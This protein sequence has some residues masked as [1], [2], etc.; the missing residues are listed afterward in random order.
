LR[1]INNSAR[2]GAVGLT[3]KSM[4]KRFAT[5]W[6][7]VWGLLYWWT[8]VVSSLPFGTTVVGWWGSGM[9][10]AI[11]WFGTAVLQVERPIL[12]EPTGSG[13]GV[14]SWIEA[15]L[16]LVV[17]AGAAVIWLVATRHDNR[18][19]L[20]A[21]LPLVARNRVR[22]GVGSALII[23]GMEKVFALQMPMY[24]ALLTDTIGSKSP[25]GMLWTF[26]GVSSGYQRLTGAAELIAGILL[27]A[28]RTTLL[29][30]LLGALFMGQVFAMNLFFDVP[31]KLLSFALMMSCVGL[32]FPELSRLLAFFVLNRATEPSEFSRPR[33]DR[34]APQS[35]RSHWK[36]RS[37]QLAIVAL[38]AV[39]MYTPIR[40]LVKIRKDYGSNFATKEQKKEHRLYQNGIRWIQE[41]PDNQ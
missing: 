1:V 11:R 16:V 28:K 38:F 8:W 22:Y 23:Y 30:A 3:C 5:M 34:T 12:F 21:Q 32:A 18:S 27:F 40:H 15:L 6:A 33:R 19:G 9:Q 29:G 24:P 35:H 41:Q 36:S 10:P 7:S 37:S 4:T 14:A 39:A 26:M 13:D 25:M 20:R 17:A 31:V 2:F